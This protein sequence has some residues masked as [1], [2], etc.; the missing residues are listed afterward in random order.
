MAFKTKQILFPFVVSRETKSFASFQLASSASFRKLQVSQTRGTWQRKPTL[1]ER[2]PAM[3]ADRGALAACLVSK[4]TVGKVSSHEET[5]L[6]LLPK[7]ETNCMLC[8]NST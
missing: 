2:L 8:T 1:T 7:M 3:H 5:S 6:T 4:L